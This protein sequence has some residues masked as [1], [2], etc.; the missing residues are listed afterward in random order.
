MPDTWKKLNLKDQQQI[1]VLNAPASFDSELNRLEDVTVNRSI[2]RTKQI[3]FVLA[4]VTKRTEIET[5]TRKISDK[6]VGDA[7][8]WFAYPKMSSKKYQ[9]NFSRDAGWEPLGRVGLEGVRQVAID[10]DW[11]ALRF[12]RVE[13]IKT[14]TRDPK[15]AHST[16]GKARVKNQP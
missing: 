2:G 12:R 7:V 3:D 1:F 4:F 15:R 11:S 14:M 6:A 16:V 9:C 13:F 10:D 5:I 8:I